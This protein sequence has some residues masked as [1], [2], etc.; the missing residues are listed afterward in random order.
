MFTMIPYRPSMM[1]RSVNPFADDFFRPFFGR[2]EEDVFR[3]DVRDE[4]ENYLLEAELP[5]VAKENIHVDIENDVLTIFVERN[6]SKD[7]KNEK[8]YV[9]R[10]RRCG[11]MSRA[12]NVEGIRKED[13]QAAYE[14]GVLRL[15]LPKEQPEPKETKRSIA[16]N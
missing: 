1:N 9:I 11:R 8:G 4:G 15:T 2:P 3:V 13:I 7:E 12:F 16:I 5:G 14:D 6:E 10:E